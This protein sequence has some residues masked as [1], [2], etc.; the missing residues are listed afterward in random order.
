MYVPMLKWKQGE[1]QALLRLDADIKKYLFP[2]IDIPPIGWNFEKQ[3]LMKTIDEH[4]SGFGKKLRDKWGRKSAFIDLVLLDKNERMI[5][6]QHPVEYIFDDIRSY[7]E[8]VIPATAFDRDTPYQE[9]VKN[10]VKLDENGL[11][12]RLS[13]SDLIKGDV[14]LHLISMIEYFE[15]DISSVDIVIDLAAPNFQPLSNFVNALRAATSNIEN[16]KNCR[17]FTIAAT[18][19]PETMGDL[20]LGENLLDRE[21]WKLFNEYM[22]LLSENERRPQFGDYTIAHPGIVNLDMRFIKPAASL[23]YT[24]DD[25]W[26]IIKGRNVRDYKFKQYVDMCGLV[27]NSGQFTHPDYSLGD[28]YIYNCSEG[29]ESTGTLTTWRWVGVNHHITKVVDDLANLH[30]L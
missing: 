23:R 15:V 14:D 24:V 28:E 11:C 2:F 25:K 16:L 26:L 8:S 1:Y 5:D 4:L 30:V 13:F 12:I 19:F 10:V 3:R 7:S 18:A 17:S 20:N 22:S 21:E 29:D 9:A 6:G 27:V